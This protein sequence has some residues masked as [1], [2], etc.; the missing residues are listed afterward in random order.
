MSETSSSLDQRL[1][2]AVRRDDAAA[3]ERWLAA[4]ADPERPDDRNGWT[5][6]LHAVHK[7]SE[8]AAAAL[9]AGGAA[10]DTTGTGG[11]SPLLMAASYGDAAMIGALIAGG[12][13]PYRGGQ[14]WGNALEAA[15]TG[16]LDIDA[17]TFGRCQTA[18]VRTLLE[19]A[20]GL[21]PS[22]AVA[23]RLGPLIAY[24]RGCDEIEELLA[25]PPPPLPPL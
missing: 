11:Q 14:G 21:R 13:D 19:H 4:G 6:L 15:L 25:T 23:G 17:F 20:P 2:R 16:A 5:P 7:G 22:S 3:V 10:P 12:A 9:L 24:V 1:I 8:A 18:A